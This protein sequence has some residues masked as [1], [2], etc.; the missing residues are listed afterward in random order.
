ME[1][2]IWPYI[3]FSRLLAVKKRKGFGNMFRHQFETLAILIEYGYSDPVIIKAS[4]LHDILEDGTKIGISDLERI[5]TIDEDGREV[6]SLVKE[7][8]I[9]FN[10][11]GKE[12]KKQ[13]LK[14]IMTSG[15]PQ[16]KI[17]KLA[18]RLSNINSLALSFEPSFMNKYITETTIDILP[19]S[20]DID[21]GMSN[22]L[23]QSIIKLNEQFSL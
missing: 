6:Y 17:L 1:I 9:R 23:K 21:I 8:S 15:S 12:P 19:Y 5:I 10:I 20:D 4:L 7:L 2:N 11:K 16:A 18:D 13:Y 14:R 22:E 3:E